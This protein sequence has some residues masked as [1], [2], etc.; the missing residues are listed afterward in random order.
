MKAIFCRPSFGLL[1]LKYSKTSGSLARISNDKKKYKM[2]N[3]A[4]A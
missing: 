2:F 4:I 1:R 3:F